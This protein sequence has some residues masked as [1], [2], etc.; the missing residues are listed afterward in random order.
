MIEAIIALGEHTTTCKPIPIVR[1]KD[2]RHYRAH[3]WFE[4]SLDGFPL[5]TDMSDVCMFFG[6]GV[7]VEPDGFCKWGEREVER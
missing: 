6:D 7:K 4:V 2:C 1:C 3:K 5:G